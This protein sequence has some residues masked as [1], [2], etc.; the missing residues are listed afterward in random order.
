MYKEQPQP[1][2]ILL[3]EYEVSL[4]KHAALAYLDM[5][6]YEFDEWLNRDNP[7]SHPTI[8]PIKTIYA[9]RNAFIGGTLDAYAENPANIPIENMIIFYS[10]IAFL[11]ECL[12]RQENQEFINDFYAQHP[13]IS[14]F[15]PNPPPSTKP[16]A[17]V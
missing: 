8:S 15:I 10:D 2:D 12:V 6:N 1:L 17:S 9:L 13:E 3:A 14:D 7:T 4:H 5:L 16:S 11:Y